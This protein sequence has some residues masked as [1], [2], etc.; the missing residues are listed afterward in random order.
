[1]GKNSLEGYNIV[2]ENEE[3]YYNPLPAPPVLFT[4]A[5]AVFGLKVAVP[6]WPGSENGFGKLTANGRVVHLYALNQVVRIDGNLNVN[7]TKDPKAT[8]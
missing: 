1:M 3:T 8:S 4:A 5:P 6:E 7:S 2:T